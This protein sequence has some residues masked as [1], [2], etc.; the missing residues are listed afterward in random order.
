MTTAKKLAA[1]QAAARRRERWVLLGLLAGLVAVVVAGGIGLQAWRTSRPPEAVPVPS[2]SSAPV[3]ITSGRPI[4]F[5]EPS[6][7]VVVTLF[8]DFH[9][10]HCAEFEEQFA[11]VLSEARQSG[12]ARVEVY[13]MAF[14]DEGSAAAANAFACA[15]EAGFGPAYY[16]G[17]F[18]NRT[19]SWHDDQLIALAGAVGGTASPEFTSC[20]TSRAHAGWVDSINAAA[21]QRGVTGTPTLLVD[22]ARTDVAKLTPDALAAMINP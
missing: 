9:C 10:P 3:T 21:A 13:P 8:S 5:G 22:G 17:L 18:A 14:I 19:L 2:P 1:E 15:A 6:A 16:A 12:R 11:P 20:V 7:P 4:V